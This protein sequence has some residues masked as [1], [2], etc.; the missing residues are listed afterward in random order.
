M[1]GNIDKAAA[2]M[3]HFSKIK[4]RRQEFGIVNSRG[5]DAS[6]GAREHKMKRPDSSSSGTSWRKSSKTKNSKAKKEYTYDTVLDNIAPSLN[7][8]KDDGSFMEKVSGGGKEEDHSEFIPSRPLPNA[9]PDTDKHPIDRQENDVEYADAVVKSNDNLSA[10]A[11]LRAKLGGKRALPTPEQTG[12]H[13]EVVLPLVDSKGRAAPG[14]FGRETSANMVG[15]ARPPK[16]VQRYERG[17]KKRYFADDDNVDLDTLVRRTKHK[18]DDDMD[19]IVA[20]NI[21]K[22]SRY[23]ISELDADDEYDFDAGV[24]LLETN[25]ISKESRRRGDSREELAKREKNRQIKDYKRL[26][27]AL[28]QCR[29]CFTSDS[30][31]KHLTVSIGTAAYLAL[32]ERGRIVPGHCC[33]IPIEHVASS[34]VADESLWDEMRNFKKCVLQMFAAQGKRCI[35]FETALRPEDNRSHAFVECIPLPEEAAARAPMYFRKAIDD[36]TS[37]WSQHAAKKFIETESRHLQKR[38]PPNFPYFHVEFGLASGF[39]HVIDN[40]EDFDPLLARRVLIG[41]LRLPDED[42]HRR[43]SR[44]GTEVQRQWVAEFGSKFKEFD[45]TNQL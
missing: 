22:Q 35:F 29:L 15:D 11:L 18:I 40:P 1:S 14:A 3:A 39:V 10:A 24:E 34:R 5:R 4:E 20:K 43:I 25:K 32:P 45:W 23:K 37:D 30:R 31:P 36:A 38:I 2:P 6:R 7:Q 28:K 12:G 19:T 17:E 27:S 42:M 44:E 8:Y 41:L 21:A 13:E 26:S 16:R 33:V 9:A